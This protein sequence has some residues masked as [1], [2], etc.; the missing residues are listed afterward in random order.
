[1]A[2]NNFKELSGIIETAL[3]ERGMTSECAQ[4][5][6]GEYY[7]Q[8]G[9][10]INLFHDPEL[11]QTAKQAFIELQKMPAEERRQ[12]PLS[13]YNP[14]NNS[15]I[16]QI[17]ASFIGGIFAIAYFAVNANGTATLDKN[18]MEKIKELAQIKVYYSPLGNVPYEITGKFG[19]ERII[20]K[21]KVKEYTGGPDTTGKYTHEGIDLVDSLKLGYSDI[22]SISDGKV[23]FRGWKS[24]YGYCLDI[25]SK[26]SI[27]LRYAHLSKIF[28]SKKQEMK[29]GQK[30]ARMGKSGLPK[31]YGR[32]LHLETID[33]YGNLIDPM[34]LINLTSLEQE[35]SRKLRLYAQPDSLSR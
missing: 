26:D 24:G 7:R 22:Y 4:L 14:K 35:V 29:K 3:L 33:K 25:L 17:A 13:N 31:S 20:V 1:M 8:S 32:H 18:E 21:G 16:I 34:Q 23:I 5:R 2:E 30:I 15:N 12:I 9:I 28:V 19:E 6:K 11:E 27:K 10:L